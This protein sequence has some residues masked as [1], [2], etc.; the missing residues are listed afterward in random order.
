MANTMD[1]RALQEQVNA[2]SWYAGQNGEGITRRAVFH[3]TR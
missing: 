2:L 1:P 3:A